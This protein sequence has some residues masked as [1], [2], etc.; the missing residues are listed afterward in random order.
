MAAG[1]TYVPIATTTLASATST[2]T[3]SSIPGT[4]TDLVLIGIS[5]DSANAGG[6]IR[7]NGDTATNYSKTKMLGNGS[8][9]T[10]NRTSSATFIYITGDGIASPTTITESSITHIMNYSNTTINKTILT[11]AGQAAYGTSAG[12]GLWRSTAAITSL[13]LTDTNWAIGTT[14]TLYGIAAA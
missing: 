6:Y 12:V 1:A 5:G 10:S 8:T 7:F 9:A 3:F 13:T 11:R 2:I 4:Y 14:F